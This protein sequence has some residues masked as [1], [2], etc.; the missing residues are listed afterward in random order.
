MESSRDAAAAEPGAVDAVEDAA[1]QI[2][3][4]RKK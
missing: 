4:E 2:L 3:S 1:V